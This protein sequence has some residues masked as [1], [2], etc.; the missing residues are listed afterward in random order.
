MVYASIFQFSDGG[1]PDLIV[2]DGGDATLMAH[3]GV[4]GEQ[5]PSALEYE[6]SSE[7]ERELLAILKRWQSPKEETIGKRWRKISAA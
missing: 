7:D 5:D 4:R 3:M 1:G 6:A 2:D